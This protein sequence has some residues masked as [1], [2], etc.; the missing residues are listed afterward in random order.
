M[1]STLPNFLATPAAPGANLLN[2]STLASLLPGLTPAPTAEGVPVAARPE[3]ATLMPPMPAA[4]APAVPVTAPTVP[5]AGSTPPAAAQPVVVTI[6]APGRRV[7]VAPVANSAR[8]TTTRDAA[9]PGT[10]SIS[11]GSVPVGANAW[12][13][14]ASTVAAPAMT[15][16]PIPSG[17]AIE[18]VATR[19]TEVPAPLREQAVAFAVTLLQSLLPEVTVPVSAPANPAGGSNASLAATACPSDLLGDSGSEMKAPAVSGQLA[20]STGSGPRASREAGATVSLTEANE[21]PVTISARASSQPTQSNL[22]PVAHPAAG[23]TMADELPALPAGLPEVTVAADRS[24]REAG[25]GF[26]VNAN[27]AANPPSAN[28]LTPSPGTPVDPLAPLAGS[29]VLSAAPGSLVAFAADGAVEVRFS[30]PHEVVDAVQLAATAD[31]ETPVAIHAELALPGQ[32]VLR[33]EVGEAAS[34]VQVEPMALPPQRENFA[35]KIRPAR[36][37]LETRAAIVE[38]NFVNAGGKEDKALSPAAG[39]TV[40]EH[41]PI[42]SAAPTEEPRAARSPQDP[43]VLPVRAEFQVAQTSAERITVPAP[44]PS[45]QTFAARAVET[46]TGLVEAQFSAS[47]QKSGSVHLRLK[48]GGEDL[49]VRVAIRDGAVHTNFHTDSAPLRAAIER[50]WS[51]VAAASPEQMQRYVEPVFT[52]GAVAPAAPG[53]ASPS[54]WARSS[55][56][57]AQ[58]DA[59]QQRAPREDQP[60]FNRRSL[61]SE[62]FVPEPPAPR[63]AAFLPTSLRLSALA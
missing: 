38:R 30:L 31:T 13:L 62:S 15:T 14:G 4:P 43:L 19:V 5:V 61:M 3:F 58:P 41:E 22:A 16:A 33:L 26:G 35:G 45:G 24:P 17:E 48:F 32:P 53:E 60:T 10:G 6:A 20:H 28:R 7:A 18:P 63:V 56:Q 25:E 27:P 8:V 34:V 54:S 42:M 52:A 12:S 57:Q 2:A 40:A 55:Q 11:P 36:T 59:Q 9:D 47:M 49:S 21:P 44:G 50:E 29:Q 39:I 23:F 37:P 51:A 1:N 46:V